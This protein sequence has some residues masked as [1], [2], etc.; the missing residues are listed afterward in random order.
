MKDMFLLIEG[1]AFAQNMKLN[2]NTPIT[3]TKMRLN[4]EKSR[5][6]YKN[7][8]S[9]YKITPESKN[10]FT[11]SESPDIDTRLEKQNLKLDTESLN[12]FWKFII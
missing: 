8:C 5:R 2:P 6:K 1:P 3:P 9:I 7:P 10:I 12:K 11:E 4:S